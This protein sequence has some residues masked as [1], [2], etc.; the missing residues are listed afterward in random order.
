[1]KDWIIMTMNYIL[2]DWQTLLIGGAC[3]VSMVVFILGCFK[4]FIK[5]W[6]SNSTLRKVLFAWLSIALNIPA[7]AVSIWIEDLP[8][9]HFWT[10]AVIN[11]VGTILVYFVYENTALRNALHWLGKKIITM[12]FS[13]VVSPEQAKQS[14][15]KEACELAMNA[16]AQEVVSKKA[17]YNVAAT[18][19]VEKLLASTP[20][21]MKKT[22]ANSRYNNSIKL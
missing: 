16:Q 18:N 20:S 22:S 6:V 4:P 5:R 15:H 13:Q 1:M 19:D 14:I 12:L 11:A 2:S 8:T 17:T 10:L 21:A 7:T 9:E 3:A